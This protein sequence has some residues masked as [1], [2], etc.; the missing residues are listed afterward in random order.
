MSSGLVASVHVSI[1][2]PVDKVWDALVNPEI[3]RL[4]MFGTKVVSEWKKGGPI[5]WKGIWEGREYEDR[6]TILELEPG[7]L[8]SYSHFSPLSGEPDAPENHHR[9]TIELSRNGSRTD[10][11]LR[12]GNNASEEARDHSERN[13]KT[14]LGGLKKLLETDPS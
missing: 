4:Y 14:M 6:G 9:V 2:S 8:L 10:L 5:A 12:Q 11:W 13:W 3:I 1:D 7:R